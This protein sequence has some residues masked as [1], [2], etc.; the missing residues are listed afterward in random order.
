MKAA[1]MPCVSS[2]SRC[3]GECQKR[4]ASRSAKISCSAG[5]CSGASGRNS[6]R[7]VAISGCPSMWL[8][9][10]SLQQE[11]KP[12]CSHPLDNLR[13]RTILNR[14]VDHGDDRLDLAFAALADPTRRAILE[15]LGR[16]DGIAV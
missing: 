7:S 12:S 9:W 15:R 16:E 2:R 10:Q 13:F 3:G 1:I 4:I 8:S 5:P 11:G 6:K 14:M